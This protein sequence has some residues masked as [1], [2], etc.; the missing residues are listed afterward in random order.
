L[1]LLESE[2]LCRLAIDLLFLRLDLNM[3]LLDL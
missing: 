1:I 2:D 3:Q